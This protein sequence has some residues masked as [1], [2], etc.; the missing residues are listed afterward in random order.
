MSGIG[1]LL[2]GTNQTIFCMN[3]KKKI[4]LMEHNF[5]NDN[6]KVLAIAIAD[7]NKC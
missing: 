5:F 1:L 3:I 7:D 2:K 6:A 4:I